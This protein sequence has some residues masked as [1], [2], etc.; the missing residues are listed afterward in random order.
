MLVLFAKNPEPGQVKTR[1]GKDIGME[2]ACELYTKFLKNLIKE[3][4]GKPYGFMIF[5][6]SLRFDLQKLTEHAIPVERQ[7]GGDLGE[8][9]LNAFKQLCKRDEKVIIIGAD[10]PDLNNELVQQAFM[11]LDTNDVVLGPTKDGGY[12]LI[13]MKEP[14][15]LFAGIE[16][17]TN[18]VFKR[19]IEKIREKERSLFLLPEKNDID[20]LEDLEAPA[21]IHP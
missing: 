6:P 17:S 18:T 20:T 2:Q 13:G 16:W 12:Y 9:M 14:H 7:Q 5:T 10:L 15:D 3:H 11:A 4:L 19:T 8:K 1:L 21:S